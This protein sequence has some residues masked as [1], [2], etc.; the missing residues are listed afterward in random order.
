VS[1]HIPSLQYRP[2]MYQKFLTYFSAVLE[3]EYRNYLHRFKYVAHSNHNTSAKKISSFIN[4]IFFIL[5]LLLVRSPPR[6]CGDRM[7]TGNPVFVPQAQ[8]NKS[9]RVCFKRSKKR[10]ILDCNLK[11]FQFRTRRS[12]W[13]G[14]PCL[15][16]L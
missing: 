11:R 9:R 7:Y 16:I 1:C 14:V 12:K 2:S 8:T 3:S 6:L 5:K 4:S 10:T 15:W 13:V